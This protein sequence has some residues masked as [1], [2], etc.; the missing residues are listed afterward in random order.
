MSQTARIDVC[1]RKISKLSL[2]VKEKG[3]TL[4]I[5]IFQNIMNDPH[6]KKYHDLN[7]SKLHDKLG[8][9]V[10][11]EL[12]YLAGFSR[13]DNKL[14]FDMHKLNELMD[15]H[16]ILLQF[17]SQN[18]PSNDITEDLINCVQLQRLKQILHQYQHK[19]FNEF[20]KHDIVSI[21]NDFLYL[22]QFGDNENNFEYIYNYL[23]DGDAMCSASECNI[24]CRNFRDRKKQTNVIFDNAATQIL[25]KIHSFYFHSF[26]I[27]YRLTSKERSFINI[28]KS[29][30][31]DDDEHNK[32]WINAR[33]IQLRDTIH[34]KRKTMQNTEHRTV[35]YNQLFQKEEKQDDGLGGYKQYSFG[36]RFHYQYGR[37][38][39]NMEFGGMH[40]TIK[41]EAKYSSLKEELTTNDIAVLSMQ[42]FD[43]E[44]VKARLHLHSHHC[45][46]VFSP[47]KKYY[48]DSRHSWK[49]PY[50]FKLEYVLALMVYCNYTCLSY[51]F[52]K[53][54]RSNNGKDHNEF[55][56]LAA[57]L[58]VSVH[59]FG[60]KIV[61]G[62]ISKFYHGIDEELVF[63]EFVGSF[64]ENIGMDICCPLSTSSSFE[65]ATRFSTATGII[66]EFTGVAVDGGGISWCDYYS[67][68]WLSDFPGEH[69]YLF[70]QNSTMHMLEM[71]SIFQ[72]KT[73]CE[74]G[75]I[76][77][78]LKFIQIIT[79]NKTHLITSEISS[80]EQELIANIVK[81]QISLAIKPYYKSKI[82]LNEYAQELVNNYCAHKTY[83]WIDCDLLF[84]YFFLFTYCW[85]LKYQWLK[86]KETIAL[87]PNLN[88][89]RIDKAKLCE[90]TLNEILTYLSSIRE[91]KLKLI[92]MVFVNKNSDL[93][94]KDAISKYE[95]QFEQIKFSMKMNEENCQITLIHH[96]YTGPTPGVYDALLPSFSIN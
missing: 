15:V 65:V 86:L 28:S 48:K 41:V 43:N 1:L 36:N 51:E 46:S 10:F 11:I 56:F 82:Q 58:K 85:E 4:L 42:Q 3:I 67:T 73:G 91:P 68:A 87:F 55:Y 95:Q 5:R 33:F 9:G 79:M 66:V 27:G 60:T 61:Y 59:K 93:R 26:D 23:S 39:Y 53:T 12:L 89:I 54:Y 40:G 16:S 90:S 94:L 32:Q 21:L 14:L 19:E 24:L 29:N 50:I 2:D 84:T 18:S 57:Y 83:I 75:K 47:R 80:E 34:S 31:N 96:T 8:E 64:P 74:Y 88:K 71:K 20:I 38:E 37:E 70:I 17:E 30:E 78:A 6:N 49:E 25:D 76:L 63:P 62:N 22:L 13:N 92:K 52:S 7:L 44:L 77:T 69:E 72:V 35:K 81:H 45:K